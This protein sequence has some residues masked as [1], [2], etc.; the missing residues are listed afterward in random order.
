MALRHAGV[1]RDTSSD[2]ELGT[3]SMPKTL[4]LIGSGRIGGTLARLALDAGLEVVLSNSRGPE[5]LS[6]LV[7]ELGAGARAAT[8]EAAAREGDVVAVSIPLKGYEQLSAAALAGKTVV[9]AMN[10]VPDR[11]GRIDALERGEITSSELLQRHLA[12]SHVVKAV[13][14]IDYLRLRSSARPS[15][16]PDRSALPIAGDDTSAKQ[17][18]A[19]LLDLLGFDTMDF[20][21]LAESW[22]SHP[23]TPVWVYPYAQ[24]QPE[25]LSPQESRRRFLEAPGNPVS[26]DR[27]KELLAAAVR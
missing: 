7:A 17:E 2:Y 27:L 16:A 21:S 18:V 1:W 19:Q 23:G 5:T 11:D 6:E 3:R 8:P 25:G 4:A 24:P 12:D 26:V 10:Y 22:R 15:G 14:N 13:N 9:D 20:G